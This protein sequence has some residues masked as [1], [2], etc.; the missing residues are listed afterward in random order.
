[1]ANKGI[2]RSA[3][4]QTPL[5]SSSIVVAFLVIGVMVFTGVNVKGEVCQP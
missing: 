5:V 2:E 1:M 3:Y 4:C